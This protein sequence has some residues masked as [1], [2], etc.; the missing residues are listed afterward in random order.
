[1]KTVHSTQ[2]SLTL[3]TQTISKMK[4]SNSHGRGLSENTTSTIFTIIR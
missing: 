1:M 4:P 3:R 2:R